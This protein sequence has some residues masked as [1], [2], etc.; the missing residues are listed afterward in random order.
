[1]TNGKPILIIDDEPDQVRGL[2]LEIHDVA[3]IIHPGDLKREDL[4][5]ASLLL[6]DHH[7]EDANWPERSLFPLTCQPRDGLALAAILQS[8]LRSDELGHASLASPIAVALLSGKLSE[9]TGL[10]RPSEHIAARACGL[11]WAFAKAQST[12]LEHALP[13]RVRSF[14]N[15]VRALPR[16]WPEEPAQSQEKLMELLGVQ[17][18]D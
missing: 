18:A 8:L 4:R 17:A 11:D 12:A 1:M 5:A 13:V 6:I 3:E 9:V 15:A 10:D 16:S 14:F 7:L 2:L